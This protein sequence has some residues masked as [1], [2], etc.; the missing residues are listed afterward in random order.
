ML[1]GVT[2]YVSIGMGLNYKLKGERGIDMIPHLSFWKDFPLLVR[3][4]VIWTYVQI[5][6]RFGRTQPAGGGQWERL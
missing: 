3:D 2:L 6:A 4:G 5:Q 1:I